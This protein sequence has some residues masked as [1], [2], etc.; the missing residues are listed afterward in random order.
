M[1]YRYLPVILILILLLLSV[2]SCHKAAAADHPRYV[3]ISPEVAEIL[4]A[5][6]A[7]ASIVGVTEEC[8]YPSALA[9]KEIVGKFGAL[10]KEKII[11]LNPTIIFSSALEQETIAADFKKLG[12]RV[13]SF[14]PAS[15]EDMLVGIRHLG[16]LTNHGKEADALADSLS[17]F[18]TMIKNSVSGTRPKVYLE[19]Y[20]DPLMSVADSSFVGQLIEIAGGDN[21]FSSLERDYARVKTEAVIA[22][23]PDIMICFSQ[24]SRNS[25][26]NR[27]GW[28]DIPAIKNNRIYFDA[29]ISPDLIQRAGPR[30]T[31]GLLRLQEIIQDWKNSR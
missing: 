16:K 17:G 19:I 20:R 3:V 8:T 30:I 27:K 1:N 18:I 11:A 12:Y 22:S 24:D 14:Y 13:E 15:I 21:V 2:V 9:G 29:D 25:I 28:Q 26:R 31:L 7:E 5:I 10:D 23:A 4:C 6:G